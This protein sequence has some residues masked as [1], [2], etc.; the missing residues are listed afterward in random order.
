VDSPPSLFTARETFTPPPPGSK[1][2]A[3]QRILISLATLSTDVLLSIVG[4]TVRVT[5]LGMY[6]S[7]D[8]V[9]TS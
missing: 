2:G 9:L 1:V 3:A 5:I 7:L 4:F 6:V 8:S